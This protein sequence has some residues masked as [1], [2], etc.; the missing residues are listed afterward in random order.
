MRRASAILLALMLLL[1]F[2]I[3]AHAESGVR[4]LTNGMIAHFDTAITNNGR[5]LLPLTGAANLLG[6]TVSEADGKITLTREGTS[7]SLWVDSPKAQVN[8][9]DVT[10]PVPA[11]TANGQTFVPLRFL[12]EAAGTVV[13]WNPQEQLIKLTPLSTFVADLMTKDNQGDQRLTGDLTLNYGIAGVPGLT[14]DM[15]AKLQLDS[16]I[17]KDEAL[18]KLTI[19]IDGDTM[20]IEEA[21]V[22]GK[23]YLRDNET[24]T[25]SDGFPTELGADPT[26]LFGGFNLVQ[27]GRD[28]AKA[29][30]TTLV[31]TAQ[32]DETVVVIKLDLSAADLEAMLQELSGALA[33]PVP[34]AESPQPSFKIDH[35][36]FTYWVNPNTMFTHRVEMDI[37]AT[38]SVTD[39]QDPMQIHMV[40]KGTFNATP[41]SQPIQFPADL[42]K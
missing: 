3:P 31:G 26:A 16:Q 39:G 34:D 22:G 37:D 20:T 36:T 5:I 18:T 35:Y 17:Y 7:I 32:L 33:G 25:W 42:P 41:L 19:D 21:V 14:I 12:A 9:K 2:A 1:V 6:L 40:V 38:I 30:K 23:T 28:L 13:S 8:G 10:M 27:I 11:R 4:V 15:G 24:N 29:A